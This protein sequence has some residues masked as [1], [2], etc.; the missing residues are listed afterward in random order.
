MKSVKKRR[1]SVKNRSDLWAACAV[2]SPSCA[3]AELCCRRAVL[4][5][6]CAVAELCGRAEL[7]L[8]C[9][10]AVLSLLCGRAVLSPL[11]VDA[12]PPGMRGLRGGRTVVAAPIIPPRSRPRSQCVEDAECTEREK[13]MKI[14]GSRRRWGVLV[15]GRWTEGEDEAGPRGMASLMTRS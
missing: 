5:P 14:P 11:C 12:A 10:R 2:R 15:E 9:V 8:M 4:S 1:K 7:S 6:S 3:V 13:N